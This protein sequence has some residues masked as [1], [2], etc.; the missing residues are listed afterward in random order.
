MGAVVGAGFASGQE[1]VQFFLAF[2]PQGFW[3]IS[4][5]GILFALFGAATVFLV[6]EENISSPA[7]FFQLGKNQGIAFLFDLGLNLFLF[8][9]LGVMLT[10]SRA[11]LTSLF[12]FSPEGGYFLTLGLLFLLLLTKLNGLIKVNTFFIPSLTGATALICSFWLGEESLLGSFEVE[13]GI[14]NSWVG[15]NWL[16]A[17]LLYVAY[18]SLGALVVLTALPLKLGKS[19]ENI[20]GSFLGGLGLGFL[21]LLMLS[22]L[23][24]PGPVSFQKELPMLFLAQKLPFFF[25]HAY[26]FLAWLAMLTTAGTSSYGL[27]CRLQRRGLPYGGALLLVLTATLVFFHSRLSTLIGY[28]Y[29]LCGYFGLAIF[30]CLA[31]NILWNFRTR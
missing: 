1:L 10:G 21:A 25:Y 24:R 16:W 17:V 26:A 12:P 19:P 28:F 20:R 11:L 29:P 3:G 31:L 4:I 6:Q 5:A 15:G 2:G 13:K 23:A 9:S 27:A 8:T 22:A 14:E 18:N 30:L 7:A